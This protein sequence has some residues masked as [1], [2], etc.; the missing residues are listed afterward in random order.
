[1]ITPIDGKDK[2]EKFHIPYMGRRSYPF[3]LSY[4][5][6]DSK[7]VLKWD[8]ENEKVMKGKSSKKLIEI[9]QEL[10]IEGKL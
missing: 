2:T 1:M 4:V 5:Y 8:L 6:K 9:I 3:R 10:Q 7:L